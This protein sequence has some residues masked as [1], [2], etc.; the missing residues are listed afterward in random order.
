MRHNITLYS[1]R[2]TVSIYK[3]ITEQ[4]QTLR[5]FVIFLALFSSFIFFRPRVDQLKV[6]APNTENAFL[7]VSIKSE[8]CYE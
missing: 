3:I 7:F 6:W 2:P 8:K 4:N 1:Q 5:I